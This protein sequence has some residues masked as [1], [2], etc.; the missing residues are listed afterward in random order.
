MPESQ[1][2]GR[3]PTARLDLIAIPVLASVPVLFAVLL[4]ACDGRAPTAPASAPSAAASK[5]KNA[6]VRISPASDT[7]DA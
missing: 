7:L 6:V 4:L 1:P 3:S 2:A 5:G